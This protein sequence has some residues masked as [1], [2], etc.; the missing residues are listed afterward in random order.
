MTRIADLL[1]RD[2]SARA[3]DVTE[4]EVDN[5]HPQLSAAHI[6]ETI[7]GVL[8]K[9][10]RGERVLR[11]LFQECGQALVQ[12]VR[13]EVCSRR[14]EFD[15]D[16]FVRFYPYLPHLI[17]L[18]SE[19][20]EGVWRHPDSPRHASDASRN[21]ARQVSDMLVSEQ[22][23]LAAQPTGVLV[24]IDKIYVL[25]ERNLP[26]QRRRAIAEV[27]GR[28]SGPK[29][30]RVMAERIARVLCLMEFIETDL[31]RSTANLAALMMQ[32]VEESPDTSTIAEILH[33]L[34]ESQ[35]V[36]QTEEG[37]T[38]H[39]FDKLRRSVAAVERLRSE[40]GVVN[41]RLPGFRN[42]LIQL[43]KRSLARSLA[44]YT[45]PLNEFHASV[46]RLLDDIVW[47][48]GYLSAN[49]TDPGSIAANADTLDRLSADVVALEARLTR[50][51]KKGTAME[52][53][54]TAAPAIHTP[55][56]SME[57]QIEFLREKLDYVQE[58]VRAFVSVTETTDPEASGDEADKDRD[59][60]H[61]KSLRF[62][63]RVGTGQD[64]TAYIIGLFGTG[65]WYINELLLLH[66][67]ERAGFFRDTIRLHPGPTSMI[68]S[69][70]ATMRHPSRLQYPPIIMSQ[71][72]EAVGSRFADSVFIYRHPLD[73]LLT[74]WVWWR[75]FSRENRMI[76]SI[77]QVFKNTDDLCAE[78]E[79]NFSEFQAF[80]ENDPA[81]FA[82]IPG[83][84]FL[85]FAEF[86]EETDLHLRAASLSSRLEDFAVDPA[87]EFSRIA[88]VMSVDLDPSRLVV[89]S[90][91]AAPYRHVAVLD[92]VPQFR[93]FVRDL[94]AD[95]KTRI[96]KMGYGIGV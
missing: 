64:R 9:N 63:R 34:S 45:R 89:A 43:G 19:I 82:A 38:L 23:S 61:G 37:W 36:R 27:C 41:P 71:I 65:R 72:M 88:A 62:H 73:S 52:E 5:D 20:A 12:N 32:H 60:W 90:P 94:D 7:D 31:P 86:V 4:V 47:S 59:G 56:E 79:R 92:K 46:S 51:E 2:L 58:Q 33:L 28:F 15:E 16:Q 44:W 14:T 21:V 96:G 69:G 84:R 68:Y 55:H 30:F 78:L 3:E 8:R 93:A 1:A 50:M 29:R 74:N 66:I 35:S 26:P 49:M 10:E 18:S 25:V 40:V 76:G 75:T 80:A 81:F 13:L 53:R 39:D 67:G 22:T 54:M 77:S 17:D 85:S 24:S 11:K 83:P 95:T 42:N 57:E 70:H 87:R 48:L 6:R 91:R